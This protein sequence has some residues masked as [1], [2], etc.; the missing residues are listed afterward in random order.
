MPYYKQKN[1]LFV[2]IPKTGGTAIE[3]AIGQHYEQTVFSYGWHDQL[4]SPYCYVSLQH[5]FYQTLVANQMRLGIQMDQPAFRVFA[6]VRNPY[7][8][9]ISDLFWFGLIQFD[10]PPEKVFQI[11]KEVYLV[12]ENMDNHPEPQYKYV[13]D[14]QGVLYPHIRIFKCEELNEKQD[15]LNAFLQMHINIVDRNTNK[16]YNHYF[17]ADLIALVNTVYQRDFELFDYKMK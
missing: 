1:V 10:T 3:N 17:N 9:L 4:D 13:T 5:Q 2:H 15:E 6:V 12:C 16:Q 14:E 7:D 11:V 8:R